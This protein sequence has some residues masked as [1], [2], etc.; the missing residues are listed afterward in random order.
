MDFLIAILLQH[1]AQIPKL[2]D[3]LFLKINF[4]PIY[5]A[6]SMKLL[7]LENAISNFKAFAPTAIYEI[8]KSQF[9]TSDWC[10]E[11]Y[12]WGDQA[13]WVWTGV[14]HIFLLDVVLHSKRFILLK[15]PLK[16]DISLH[17]VMTYWKVVKT[18]ENKSS[19]FLW[20]DL[21]TYKFLR[22]P[23]HFAWLYHICLSFYCLCVPL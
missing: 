17:I 22:I 3:S 13:K 14:H 16:L 21:S 8:S 23:T 18:I 10:F 4:S 7:Y 12:M 11:S 5:M 9:W 6:P 2:Y 20:P 1:F 19:Y 15:S